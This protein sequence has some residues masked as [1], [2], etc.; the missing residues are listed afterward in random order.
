MYVINAS[1]EVDAQSN[2]PLILGV[3]IPLLV[4]MLTVVVL[5]IYVRVSI[6]R[7]PGPDDWCIAVAAVHKSWL[8]R[9]PGRCLDSA[10]VNYSFSTIVMVFDVTI[11]LLPIP[12]MLRLQMPN[13]KKMVS[14]QFSF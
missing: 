2:Y 12:F 9:I 6:L 11:F 10:P 3:T 7:S 5:R 13:R 4:L 1:P 8:P 14:L